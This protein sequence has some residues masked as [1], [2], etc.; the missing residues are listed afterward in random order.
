MNEDST[1]KSAKEPVRGA[2]AWSVKHSV[3]YANKAE[4]TDPIWEVLRESLHIFFIRS[5]TDPIW[6]EAKEATN[7]EQEFNLEAGLEG[8]SDSAPID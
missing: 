5:I 6:N 3:W 2:T 4:V 8:N 1:W 7:H